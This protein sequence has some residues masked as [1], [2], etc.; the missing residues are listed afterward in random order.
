MPGAGRN[1]QQGSNVLSMWI[2]WTF[3]TFALA[4]GISPLLERI[5]LRESY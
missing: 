4:W 5:A 3:L 2:G 1:T